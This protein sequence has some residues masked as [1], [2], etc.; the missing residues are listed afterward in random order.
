MIELNF[1]SFLKDSFPNIPVYSFYIPENAPNPSMC[2]ESIGQG[3]A[4][5]YLD[6]SEMVV[7]TIKLTVSSTDI[8]DIYNNK[9]LYKQINA[10]HQLG[11]L[12][13]IKARITNF[14]DN[15]DIESSIYERTYTITIKYIGD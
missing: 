1:I 4:Q 10:A 9:E 15:F 14:S 8:K 6:G 7:R 12:P 2:F 13:I 3:V 11:E 5:G